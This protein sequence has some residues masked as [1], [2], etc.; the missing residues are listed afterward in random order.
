M[1]PVVL[2]LGLLELQ[3][4]SRDTGVRL[5]AVAPLA[6]VVWVLLFVG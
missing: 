2:I 3:Q 4:N 6:A 5:I 1:P